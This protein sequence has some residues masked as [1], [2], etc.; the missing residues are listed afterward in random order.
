MKKINFITAGISIMMLILVSCGGG[1]NTDYAPPGEKAKLTEVFPAEIAGEKADIQKLTD[2]ENSI[3]FKATYGE[4][5]II[6]V[7]QFKNKAEADAYFKAE[8]VPVFDEMSSHSRAQVN[9]K[10]YAKGTDDSGNHYA[11]ANNNWIFG[12][13]AKDKKDFSRAV[14]AFKYISN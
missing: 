6:S 8:I 7:M 14:D 13:Y 10:W 9:G 12:I 4:T 5:T 3:A 2:V 11:W 1:Y